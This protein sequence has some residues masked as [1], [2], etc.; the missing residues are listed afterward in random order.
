LA[1][2]KTAVGRL[3]AKLEMQRLLGSQEVL[4]RHYI[5]TGN[6]GTGK[7]TVARILAKVFH[8]LGMLPTDTLV[9]VGKADLV[10]PYLGQTGALVQKQCDRAMG[11]V[12]FIDE[13]YSLANDSFG[14]E[15]ITI[16]LKRMEDDRG[17]FIVIVAGYAREM[18]QFL[19]T[20][21]GLPSRFS[22]TIDFE[23]Y[24]VEEMMRIFK[25]LAAAKSMRLS[26]GLELE[27]ASCF[28]GM[29]TRRDPSFA[30]ARTV[31]QLF[32]KL[33]AESA[34]RAMKEADD[35]AKRA[36]G[37]TLLVSDLQAVISSSR[38]P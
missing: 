27:L 21:T 13:A 24:N 3:R 2:V 33:S 8:G 30:N 11:G 5:F 10:A 23:D 35:D 7:T 15:A 6:P 1:G 19:A 17:K 25:S 26:D 34:D 16:L 22:D 31:R 12:L 18:G 29:L 9:E 37:Q 28:D 38:L 14:I 36:A 20:N 32:D 4:N